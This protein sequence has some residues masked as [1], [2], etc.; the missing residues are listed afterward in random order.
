MVSARNQA[1]LK[2]AQ[3]KYKTA[4]GRALA[5][6]AASV[7]GEVK[8]GMKG[9]SPSMPGSPPAVMDGVLR[10]SVTH[11]VDESSGTA[12][13]GTNEKYAKIHELG[14]TIKAKGGYMTFPVRVGSQ[15]KSGKRSRA[16]ARTTSGQKVSGGKAGGVYRWVKV[17]EVRMPPRPFLR[18][19][20]DKKQPSFLRTLKSEYKKTV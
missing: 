3:M 1:L 12:R 11:E 5:K 16:K 6:M 20:L 10:N 15:I 18:P 2:A 17:K 14:G 7:E 9:P 4:T 8:R 13:V 19:A